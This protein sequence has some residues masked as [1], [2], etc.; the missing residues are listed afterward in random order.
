MN[1]IRIQAINQ[2]LE[3]L[4][5]TLKVVPLQHVD[6][7]NMGLRDR[8]IDLVEAM[9]HSDSILSMH[10]GGNNLSA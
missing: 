5:E 7:S 1:G 6:F 8:T 10:I 4:V 9:T 3:K 2:I